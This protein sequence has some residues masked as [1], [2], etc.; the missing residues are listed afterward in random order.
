MVK[1]SIEEISYINKSIDLVKYASQ[2][3][4]LTQGKGK[5]NNEYWSVCPFHNDIDASLSIN[6]DKNVFNCLGCHLSGTPIIFVQ[7]YHKL[8]FP[9]AVEHL[10]NYANLTFTPKKHS[11]IMEF[12]HKTNIKIKDIKSNNRVYLPE[13]IINKYSKRPISE[14][15]EEGIP[16]EILDKYQVRY[17]DSGNRIVFPIRDI[18]GSII[19]IKGR[20]LYSN[21]KDLGI[22]KYI[23]YQ[24]IGTN[25]FLF[26]LDKNIQN[27]DNKKEC[28]IVESEKSVMKLESYGFN[29]SVAISTSN[30]NIHQINLL[31]SLQCDLVFAFDKDIDQKKIIKEIKQLTLFTNVYTIIDKEGLLGIKDSPCDQGKEVWEKL[32]KERRLI[33][34]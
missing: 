16:Q 2:Y 4:D 14:W 32:Y 17:D 24:P 5:R 11:D 15:L 20:T 25:D 28:I 19:A 26:G 23:Y 3:L 34:K 29:N 31:L 10:I 18:I 27:I 33:E 7:H 13:N 1:Y 30:I 9:K 21:Y 8:S 6:S 22:V 12:L